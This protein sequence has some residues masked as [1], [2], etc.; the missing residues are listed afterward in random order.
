MAIL[1]EELLDKKIGEKKNCF[2]YKPKIITM[3]MTPKNLIL[4]RKERV[5]NECFLENLSYD[6]NMKTNLPFSNEQKIRRIKDYEFFAKEIRENCN[7]KK[8]SSSSKLSKIIKLKKRKPLL[9]SKRSIAGLKKFPTNSG[10]RLPKI[11][12]GRTNTGS[13]SNSLGASASYKRKLSTIPSISPLNVIKRRREIRTKPFARRDSNADKRLIQRLKVS[14]M[15][16]RG[17]SQRPSP[18]RL[19]RRAMYSF[20]QNNSVSNSISFTDCVVNLYT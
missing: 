2:R 3:M 19:G 9:A 12:L 13:V 8:L 18:T 16:S 15:I 4:K 5:N 11:P 17:T 6:C 20:Q 10:L 7:E 1:L 14:G